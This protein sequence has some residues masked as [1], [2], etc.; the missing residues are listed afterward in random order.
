MKKLASLITVVAILGLSASAFAQSEPRAQFIEFDP[1][2]INA[3]T[4]GPEM[5]WVG[6]EDRSEFER[7]NRLKKSFLPEIQDSVRADAL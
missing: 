3:G 2:E 1:T 5:T 7:L 6:H 4:K